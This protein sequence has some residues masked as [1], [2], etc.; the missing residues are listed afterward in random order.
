MTKESLALL[1]S[2]MRVMSERIRVT[3]A[4]AKGDVVLRKKEADGMVARLLLWST[5]LATLLGNEAVDIETEEEITDNSFE[6]CGCGR[7]DKETPIMIPTGL[8]HFWDDAYCEGWFD[9]AMPPDGFQDEP[10][11]ELKRVERSEAIGKFLAK[12]EARSDLE[13]SNDRPILTPFICV[14]CGSAHKTLLMLQEIEN[15]DKLLCSVCKEKE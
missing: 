12:V 10:P 9:S 13:L 5:D 1:I 15:A 4:L 14:G 3:S 2:D 6:N 7:Q 8:G 11:V